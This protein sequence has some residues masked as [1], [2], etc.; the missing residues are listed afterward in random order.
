MLIFL[1]KHKYRHFNYLPLLAVSSGIYQAHS[2]YHHQS[3]QYTTGLFFEHLQNR[4]ENEKDQLGRSAWTL[5]Y[6]WVLA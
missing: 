4:M 5:C 6:L 3:K 2:H 1:F